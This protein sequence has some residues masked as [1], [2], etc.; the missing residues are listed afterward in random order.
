[1]LVWGERARGSV[2]ELA[3]RAGISFA[4]A[5]AEL[6][7]MRQAGLAETARIGRKE[8]YYAKARHPDAPLL[9]KL[10]ATEGRRDAPLSREEQALKRRL[11]AL[12]APL[13]GVKAARVAAGAE[14]A[15]LVAGVRFARRDAVIAKAL[16]VCFWKGRGALDAKSLAEQ[17]A[18]PEDKHGLGFFLELTSQLAGDRRLLGL[19]ERFRDR[20]VKSVRDFFYSS[21]PDRVRDFP[22]AE[23]W[24]FRMNMDLAVFR[25]LFEK[26]APV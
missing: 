6:K 26:F 23:K 20:R 5:H 9:R 4:S 19:A 3:E 24:G 17:V 16:P 21:G 10:V 7:V 2:S 1:V 12:G 13:R 14:C 8:V 11:K 18:L 25:G 15:V 22:L